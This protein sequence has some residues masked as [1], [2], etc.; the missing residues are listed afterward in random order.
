MQDC[1]ST[2]K[3]CRSCWE[4]TAE[5][6]QLPLKSL[7]TEDARY[8]LRV[9]LHLVRL[10]PKTASLALRTTVQASLVLCCTCVPGK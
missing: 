2:G 7:G 10:S 5:P 6:S 1:E 3:A 9:P 4:D 8:V